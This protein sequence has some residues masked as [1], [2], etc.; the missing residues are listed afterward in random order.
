[1]YSKIFFL[2]KI[3]FRIQNWS[4]EV[5]SRWFCMVV[6]RGIKK[7]LFFHQEQLSLIKKQ[8]WTRK[9]KTK[10]TEKTSL[11]KDLYGTLRGP[12]TS[13]AGGPRPRTKGP[14]PGWGP[15][16]PLWV[17]LDR[18]WQVRTCPISDFWSNFACFGFRMRFLTKCLN[19]SAWFLLEK[20]KKHVI[21]TKNLN[22][23]Q[24]FPK[25]PQKIPQNRYS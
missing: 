22:I 17:L 16:G 25:I 6:R 18:S 5:I 13:T 14:G 10:K 9:V 21:F 15:Y 1:M 20:L 2:W 23:W 12:R 11:N 24:I 19:D 4:F 7:T 8:T 3:K